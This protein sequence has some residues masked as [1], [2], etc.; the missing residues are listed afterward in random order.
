MPDVSW[1]SCDQ[2][3][4]ITLAKP[5]EKDLRTDLAKDVRVG[6]VSVPALLYVT[7]DTPF[8]FPAKPARISKNRLKNSGYSIHITHHS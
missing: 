4:C 7:I 6:N 1:N 8:E 3:H 5:P 2:D